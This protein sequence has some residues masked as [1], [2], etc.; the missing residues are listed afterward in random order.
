M[1]SAQPDIGIHL[2]DMQ[3]P[4]K[5]ALRKAAE[6]SIRSIEMS[7][8][9]GEISPSNL[10]RSGQRHLSRLVRGLGLRLDA[11]SADVPGI[12]LTDPVTV[13][14]RIDQT[15]D[16]L[17]MAADMRVPIVTAAVGAMTHP[18]DGTPSPLAIEALRQIGQHAD[19][20]GTVY[21]IRPSHD[22]A[23]AVERVLAEVGCPNLRVCVDP[24]AMMMAGVNPIKVIEQLAEQVVLAH[25]RD[26]TAGRAGRGGRETKLGEGD[27]DLVGVWATLIEAGYGG[28]H[29]IRRMDTTT[30]LPDIAH[31]RQMLKDNLPPL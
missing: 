5:L 31:A 19:T 12:R 6:L 3:L 21:A 18:D 17:R 29:I 11:L 25:A 10:T 2:D 16:I 28:S 4:P 30:P 7:A 27:V 26:A 23:D 8:V 15:R 20:F 9:A 1:A 22:D 24:A 13:S 14:E